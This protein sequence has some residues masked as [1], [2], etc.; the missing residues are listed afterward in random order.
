MEAPARRRILRAGVTV[1]VAL[2]VVPAAHAAPT[3]LST[4]F[5]HGVVAGRAL[6]LRVRARDAS[7]P[8]TGMVAGFGSHEEGFGLSSC[9]PP[10]SAGRALEPGGRTETLAAPHTYSSAG[11]RQVATTVTSGGCQSTPATTLQQATVTVVPAGQAPKPLVLIP[12]VTLPPLTL[13]QLPGLGQLPLPGAI[14]LP[15]IGARARICPGASRRFKNTRAGRRRA[16]A[17][18]L[19]LFNHERR[20]RGLRPVRL[21]RRLGRAALAHSRAMVR[22]RF[23]AHVGPGARVSLFYR[24][25]RTRYIPRRGTWAIGENIG[26]GTGSMGSP[27][28]MH[29]AWMHSTPHRHAILQPRFREVGFGVYRGA[30]Y[31]RKR[32]ATYTADFGTRR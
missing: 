27:L 23:F 7:A 26:F 6:E 2:A 1:V 15:G 31:M 5:D 19:C 13:P 25:N 9:L 24:L 8:V 30:P 11:A 18:L 22:D 17:S 16:D 12:P 29:R 32:G 28:G 21:N 14:T 3:V 4:R 20:R 10:D